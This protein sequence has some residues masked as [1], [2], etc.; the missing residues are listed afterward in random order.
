MKNLVLIRLE[1]RVLTRVQRSARDLEC[2]T[3]GG[4]CQPMGKSQRVER[5]KN[6]KLGVKKKVGTEQWGRAVIT[7]HCS[8]IGGR[9]GF[10][11]HQSVLSLDCL[12]T[13]ELG[14]TTR[15][16]GNLAVSMID[17]RIVELEASSPLSSKH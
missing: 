12:R 17:A 4:T 14:D 15:R 5:N 16:R 2:E 6:A 13:F 7:K 10:E 8:N 1:P 11:M 9:A 3:H